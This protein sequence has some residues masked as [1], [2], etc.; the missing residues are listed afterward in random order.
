MSREQASCLF[1]PKIATKQI[2][3]FRS[4]NI[5]Y[6]YVNQSLVA[7]AAGSI[8]TTPLLREQNTCALNDLDDLIEKI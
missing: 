5:L 1:T 7:L 2:E 8:R 4:Q 6:F 3:E